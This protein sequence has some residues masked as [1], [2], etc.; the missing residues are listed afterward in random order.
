MTYL[1]DVNFWL[2]ITFESH[3]HHASAKQ[4]FEQLSLS[5]GCAFCRLTQQGF[6]R[7]V[8]NP[9]AFGDEAVTLVEAPLAY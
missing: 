6:L 4:W 5:D 1:A 3:V 2:A 7:L 8:T 9:K